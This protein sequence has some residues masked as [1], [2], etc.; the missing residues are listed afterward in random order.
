M[1][2]PIVRFTCALVLGL[3]ATGLA[4]A[5]RALMQK[6]CGKCHNAKESE[7]DFSLNMLGKEPA[8]VSLDHWLASLDRVKA[9][10]MPP[11]EASKLSAPDRKKLI[12]FLKRQLLR[13]EQSNAANKSP[14]QPRR[15]NNR[16]FARSVAD[17]LMIEDV[18]T[19]L[20]TDDLI[21]DSLH[22]GFDTHGATLGFSKFHLEEYIKAVRK[23]VDA[24]ILSGAKPKSKTYDIG[25]RE[26]FAAT[27]NQNTQRPSRQGRAEGFDFLDPRSLAYF[28]PFKTVPTTGWY[29]IKIKCNA[30]D[31]GR[32]D[33]EDTGIY[34]ADPIRLR[35]IMGDRIRNFDLVDDKVQEIVLTEWLASGTIFRMLHPTDGLRLQG[36]GNFK[37]QNR[38]TAYYF[39]KY[40]PQRYSELVA[41][42]P[43]K[44]G[45]GRER[46]PDDWHNWVNYWMGPR[47]RIY[48]AQ[49]EG[50]LFQSWPPQ[51]QVA[52]LGEN[53]SAD[54]A[55]KILS[56]IAR[57][58]W[59]RDVRPGEL[60][61][62][63]ELVE[64]K[65]A[66]LGDIEALKEGIVAV[67]VSPEFL[68]L[69]REDLSAQ[70]RFA[71]KYSTLLESTI[72]SQ[73]LLA[74]VSSGQLDSFEGVKAHIAKTLA[75]GQAAPFLKAFPYA[76]LEL[77]DINFMSPDPDHY[78]HYHRKLVSEDMIG[79]V[80]HFFDHAINN[81]LP[82]PELLSADYSF[83]NADL[84]KVYGVE[85]GP[86]GSAFVKYQFA[87]G[88]RGGLLGMG[89][90][91]TSTA[92]S[93]STS[94]IHRAI[95]VMENFLGIHPTP[96]PADV[97]ITEPDVRQAKT[98][99]EIL[100]A[101]RSD[102]NCASC[103][104]AIDPFGYAF[105]NFGPDGSWRDVYTVLDEGGEESK[106][107]R[108]ASIPIDSSASFVSGRTYQNI[109]GYRKIMSSPA[110]RERFVRCFITK[111]LT[112]ANGVE[113]AKT[114]FAEIDR[115][116][117][118]SAVHQYRIVDT[119][120]A[121]IDSEL[122]RETQ[123]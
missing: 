48:G 119:I 22:H 110:N 104:Q 62:I 59:R 113:P 45:N 93:L 23:I 73:E 95:Y 5:D 116:V 92:D 55:Q 11:Q 32:Y 12:E 117:S 42:F 78:R 14:I 106:R 31:R 99:K 46:K 56:A 86:P 19:H 89:A 102:S 50:P 25:S 38:L 96:P 7:G 63:I 71:S 81:N 28:E 97:E 100:R 39:K 61:N 29:R 64:S 34:D 121:V 85:D 69:N 112:Y 67:L 10:E 37:F 33:E 54:N 114:D 94:P 60:D 16:E 111:L 66:E 80:L 17:V 79:E 76:W 90:F 84:A 74:A 3:F 36:N 123:K 120:A 58:A 65:T 41:T 88:R 35:V 122:F 82:L 109:V 44:R 13:F 27:T 2:K 68:L 26:I 40:Q 30:L 18:G 47:P 70:Q 77:N 107:N 72:P 103:H 52:L 118:V 21:G 15:M 108:P 53:P 91:L 51:R 105:E 115:I 24:T 1:G 20:P 57:R 9:D 6:H 49:I 83:I 75:A 4:N 101:H 87:D 43:K 8:K 98:I